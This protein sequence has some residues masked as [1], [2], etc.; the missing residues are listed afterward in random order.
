MA[1]TQSQ[2]N[3]GFRYVKNVYGGEPVMQTLPVKASVTYWNGNIVTINTSGSARVA[4]AADTSVYGVAAHY[5]GTAAAADR[6]RIYPFRGG[7]VFEAIMHGGMSGGKPDNYLGDSID[8]I[9]PTTTY[10][11]AGTGASTRVFQCVGF[12][13]DDAGKSTQGLRLWVIGR[14]D[15]SVAEEA[16]VHG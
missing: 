15:K 10:H 2:S 7:N 16:E 11:R 13:P 12:H 3:R 1:G 4:V 6:L 5:L 8:L 14:H 9:I